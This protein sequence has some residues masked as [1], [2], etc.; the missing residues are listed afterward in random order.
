MKKVLISL[1]LL[2]PQISL[3][4]DGCVEKAIKDG[5]RD[6]LKALNSQTSAIN[7]LDSSVSS[8]KTQIKDSGSDIVASIDEFSNTLEETLT[9][10]NTNTIN[11]IQD[12]ISSV[13]LQFS[14][15]AS[16]EEQLT[17]SEINSVN[18]VIRYGSLMLDSLI[19]NY[20]TGAYS[21]FETYIQSD[22][23]LELY[24][25]SLNVKEAYRALKASE[26]E[27]WNKGD[28]SVVVRSTQ[29]SNNFKE[30]LNKSEEL[31]SALNY[32][33]VITSEQFN[34]LTTLTLVATNPNPSISNSAQ[35]TL[36]ASSK[37]AMLFDLIIDKSPFIRI[38]EQLHNDLYP[39]IPYELSYSDCIADAVIEGD[40]CTSVYAIVEAMEQRS[41]SDIY[42][43]SISKAGKRA[44]TSELLRT[45]QMENII[46]ARQLDLETARVTNEDL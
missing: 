17:I 30:I 16:V 43:K 24:Y 7:S 2:A 46:L 15:L 45:A 29:V 34:D 38:P 28:V 41:N 14:K 27:S 21:K 39:F 35:H 3:A 36:N 4:C 10:N 19:R 18:S 37:Q 32:N 42:L 31:L 20:E 12:V 26:S 1:A 40:R 8:L 13:D 33:S 9:T 11:K 23:L 22:R 6:M 25:T 44:L 5:F